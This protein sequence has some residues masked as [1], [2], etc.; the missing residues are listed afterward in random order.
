MKLFGAI[1]IPEGST[2]FLVSSYGSR[3]GGAM[4]A[5]VFF[6]K[7]EAG[8]WRRWYTDCDD[9]Y[10]QWVNG[11]YTYREGVFESRVLPLLVEIQ[12]P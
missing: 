7:N 2:H 10:P 8:N 3:A 5:D 12:K 1:D 9:E 4:R 6:F 11:S